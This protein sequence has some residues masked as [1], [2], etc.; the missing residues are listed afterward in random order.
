MTLRVESILGGA[1]R[2]EHLR[3]PLPESDYLGYAVEVHDPQWNRPVRQ[4]VNNRRMRFVRLEGSREEGRWI[5]LSA[6]ENELRRSKL[7]TE[8]RNGLWLR[9]Q[10]RT[11]DGGA[12]WQLLWQDELERVNNR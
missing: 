8:I 7:V 9:K 12:T 3:I 2:V 6:G 11:T 1:G 5:W 10:Y 4:Y